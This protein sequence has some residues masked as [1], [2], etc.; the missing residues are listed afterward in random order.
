MSLKLPAPLP[1]SVTVQVPLTS[2]ATC[3]GLPE[4]APLDVTT[5]VKLPSAVG[6]AVMVTVIC[7]P[8]GVTE[9]TLPVTPRLNATELLPATGSKFEPLIIMLVAESARLAAL[10]VTVG[11]I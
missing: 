4:D 5:A 8:S 7:V 6:G 9:A 1:A 11:G 3:T 2:V 10:V